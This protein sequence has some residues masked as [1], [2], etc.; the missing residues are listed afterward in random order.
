MHV[1]V[2]VYSFVYINLNLYLK[3]PVSDNYFTFISRL[4]KFIEDRAEVWE[5]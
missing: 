1:C 2:R 4:N 5:N 3:I